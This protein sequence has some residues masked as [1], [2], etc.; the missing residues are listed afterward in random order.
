VAEEA[1][2]FIVEQVVRDYAVPI[3]L[4][5]AIG[6][7]SRYVE[8]RSR[9]VHWFPRS[10]KFD[11]PIAG[12]G[13]AQQ[14]LQIW[15]HTL[16]IG[17]LGW[18]A[19]KDVQIIHKSRPQHFQLQPAVLFSEETNPTGEHVIRISSLARREFTFIH[20]ISVGV[21]PPPVTVKSE[22]GRSKAMTTR[23]Q[24][25]IPKPRRIVF[26]GLI[27]IG[28]AT[29]VYWVGRISA[30]LVPALLDTLRSW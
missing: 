7:L 9:I 3:A 26:A 8:P 16:S 30:R 28:F 29:T 1:R 22:D 5:L 15:T 12:A 21:Q 23:Q 4:A 11:V 6:Y 2:D 13:G 27:I 20:I 10:V 25:V 14:N 24:F 19:A 17:N 18:R